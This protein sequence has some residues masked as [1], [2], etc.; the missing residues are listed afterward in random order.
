[1]LVLDAAAR[2]FTRAFY[3]SL[4]V[5]NT[6]QSAFDIGKKAGFYF[7]F[8]LIKIYRLTFF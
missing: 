2:A 4:I 3:L 6:V 8:C 5:G 7:S 1:M